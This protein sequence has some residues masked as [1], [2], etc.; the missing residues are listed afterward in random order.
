MNE[1]RV[2]ARRVVKSSQLVEEMFQEVN[3]DFKGA[4]DGAEV[5]DR[6]TRSGWWSDRREW[7]NEDFMESTS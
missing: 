6:T 2:D 4:Q 5:D 3:D 1:G 7:L